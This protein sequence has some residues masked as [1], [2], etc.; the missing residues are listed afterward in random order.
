MAAHTA[1]FAIDDAS[2]FLDGTVSTLTRTDG[3]TLALNCSRTRLA[4][5]ANRN[6]RRRVRWADVPVA[7]RDTVAEWLTIPA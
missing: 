5:T 6:G 2:V 3:A 7:V 1:D 4:I